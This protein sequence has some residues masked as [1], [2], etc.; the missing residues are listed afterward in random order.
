MLAEGSCLQQGCQEKKI[1]PE[2]LATF[3]RLV[4]I[5]S[6]SL[7]RRTGSFL[8]GPGYSGTAKTAG[9][10][11]GPAACWPRAAP[12]WPDPPFTNQRAATFRAEKPCSMS[13]PQEP[14]PAPVAEPHTEEPDSVSFRRARGKRGCWALPR[15]GKRG[16]SHG[17]QSLL[18]LGHP[19][20]NR[21]AL[22]P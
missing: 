17:V 12:T 21:M 13:F 19:R 6:S 2:E 18:P 5:D 15:A 4:A 9:V 16:T 1:V 3:L 8:Q 14:T 11:E 7:E 10:P 22:E 20:E